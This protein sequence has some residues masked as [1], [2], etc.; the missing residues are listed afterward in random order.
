MKALAAAAAIDCWVAL[1][2]TLAVALAGVRWR[3]GR[4]HHQRHAHHLQV[5]LEDGVSPT[6][7]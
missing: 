2:K 6:P 4:R 7:R 1:E 5:I 3:S